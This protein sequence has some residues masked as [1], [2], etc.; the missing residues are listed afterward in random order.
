MIENIAIGEYSIK[1]QHVGFEI[2]EM[3]ITI[4]ENMEL[5]I[6]LS[7]KISNL[8]VNVMLRVIMIMILVFLH[9]LFK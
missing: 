1:F 3:K 4:K 2:L 6:N 9:I 5:N 8:K 7:E